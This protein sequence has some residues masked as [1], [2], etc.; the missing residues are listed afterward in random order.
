MP[1]LPS[2]P[3]VIKVVTG[4]SDQSDLKSLN[5]FFIKY[6]GASPTQAQIA[7]FAAAIVAAWTGNLRTLYDTASVLEFVTA[8]DLTSSTAAVGSST[9]AVAGTRAGNT[10]GAGTA[11]VVQQQIARRYRGGHP[12]QYLSSGVQADLQTRQAWTAAYLTA[13]EAAWLNYV[14]AIFASGWAGAGSLVQVNVSY[15]NGFTNVTFP[16]GRTRP[17]PK[18]RLTPV[19]DIIGSYSINPKLAS[20]RRRNLQGT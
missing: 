11:T 19:V 6:F 5:R 4:V 2:V 1:A 17:V 16:S 8:E 7:T 20:Q 15:Y 14:A 3:S 13:A 18:L 9:A 12:R 10:L